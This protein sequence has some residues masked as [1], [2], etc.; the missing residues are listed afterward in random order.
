[1]K[2]QF[3]IPEIEVLLFKSE[4][5]ILTDSYGNTDPGDIDK[6][7]KDLLQFRITN[8]FPRH[9]VGGFFCYTKTR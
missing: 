2:N 5:A 4:D 6:D 8:I 7:L 1:M 9:F 3:E